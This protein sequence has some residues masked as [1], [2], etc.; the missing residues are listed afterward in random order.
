MLW[1]MVNV[2]QLVIKLPLLNVTFPQNAATFYTFIS[3]VASFE[4][5]P[6]D[7]INS[8]I[9]MF[10]SNDTQDLNFDLMGYQTNNIIKNLGSMF[11]YLIGFFA[12]VLIALFLKL[13]KD[14][15]E[16]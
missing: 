11:V 14:R 1:G 3:D 6:M 8:K 15:F 13:L 9:F 12:L 10:S 2:M 5:L 16:T 7:Y 4:L